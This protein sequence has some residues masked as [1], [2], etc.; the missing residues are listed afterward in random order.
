MAIVT[1]MTRAFKVD[2]LDGSFSGFSVESPSSVFR[3]ALYV[4]AATMGET[5]T[6]YTG[7]DEVSAPT[8]P[9]NGYTTGGQAVGVAT[10]PVWGTG[11]AYVDFD[12]VIWPSSSITAG[13]ALFYDSGNSNAAISTHTFGSDKQ[14]SGGD[15]TVQMPAP[16]TTALI[17]I[18]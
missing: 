5:T 2:M 15:F 10:L 11:V 4:T 9:L 14:S 3:L 7:T 1:A 6:A 16:D 18:A 13:G 12:D 8:S 17:R